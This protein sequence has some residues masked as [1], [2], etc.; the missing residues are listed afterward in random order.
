MNHSDIFE[1]LSHRF[2][3]TV[4]QAQKTNTTTT[5]NLIYKG[6]CQ[7]G[8]CIESTSE[9]ILIIGYFVCWVEV[10]YGVTRFITSSKETIA[11]SVVWSWIVGAIQNPCKN[12]SYVQLS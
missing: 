11:D 4:E 6:W 2:N 10:L 5:Y 3:I 12:Q 9:I 7:I 1:Y 8:K